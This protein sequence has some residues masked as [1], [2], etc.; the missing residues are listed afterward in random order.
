[1]FS[2]YNRLADGQVVAQSVPSLTRLCSAGLKE[3]IGHD[4][5][6]LTAKYPVA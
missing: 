1:V 4:T 2:P 6:I 3:L 5:I